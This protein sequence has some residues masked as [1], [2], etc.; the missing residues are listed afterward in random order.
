MQTRKRVLINAFTVR[1]LRDG[2]AP[3]RVAGNFRS[4][5]VNL[6]GLQFVL[7][8]LL[9]QWRLLVDDCFSAAVQFALAGSL[10]DE[11]PVRLNLLLG[12]QIFIFLLTK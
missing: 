8:E 3:A 9:C 1:A 6:Q 10:Q 11:F 12:L 4:T 7:T 2:F 5:H